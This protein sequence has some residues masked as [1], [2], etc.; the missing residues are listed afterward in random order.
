MKNFP[1][2]AI[3]VHMFLTRRAALSLECKGLRHSR[4]SVYALCKRE[5]G[6][7]G[8]KQSVLDQMT[9]IRDELLGEHQ[10]TTTD[11]S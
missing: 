3:D 1:K 5:Y 6:L 8:N 2:T 11:G 9:E 10:R 7:K 4:G